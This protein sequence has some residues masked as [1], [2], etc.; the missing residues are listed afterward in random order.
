MI[1]VNYC[2]LS[3]YLPVLENTFVGINLYNALYLISLFLERKWC[4]SCSNHTQVWFKEGIHGLPSRSFR[5]FFLI[6]HTHTKWEQYLHSINLYQTNQF[7]LCLSIIREDWRCKPDLVI[8]W[9]KFSFLHISNKEST[10]CNNKEVWLSEQADEQN[11][12]EY[13]KTSP[14]RKSKIHQSKIWQALSLLYVRSKSWIKQ[15]WLVWIWRG[16]GQSMDL[17]CCYVVIRWMFDTEVSCIS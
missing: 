17:Y 14:N 12:K 9:P 3:V 10:F 5:T 8:A 15:S 2:V 4:K 6:P 11:A 16:M 13:A 1:S 7:Q